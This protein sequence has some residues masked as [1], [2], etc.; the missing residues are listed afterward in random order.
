MFN[1]TDSKITKIGIFYDGGYF[2]HVSNYYNFVHPRQA[3]LSITG[4]H[5]F[6]REKVADEEGVD[7]SRCRI[8]DAHYFR[9]RYSAYEARTRNKLLSDRIF[10]DVL[11]REGVVTHFLPITPKGE[12][13]IDVWLALEAYEMTLYRQ[14]DVVVLIACDSDYTPLVRKLTALGVRVMLLG[15]D[16]DYTDQNGHKQVTTT[17]V[18]LLDEATYPIL[19]HDLID[20]KTNRNS[21][22]IANLFTQDDQARYTPPVQTANGHGP[23]NGNTVVSDEIQT[24]Q[25]VQLLSGYG[26][27]AT[28]LSSK[29]LFFHYSELENCDFNDLQIGDYVEYKLGRNEKGECAVEIRKIDE[30]ELEE[31]HSDEASY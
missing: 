3:R 9:G 29:N 17:S 14:F 8:T 22:L 16:F 30:S 13:G 28:D 11:M 23:A 1:K 15:W 25:I 19:M 7:A 21:S 5:N 10:E 31:A 18:S 27:I 24:S 12:K 20:N 2:W 6:V 4:I 26:F